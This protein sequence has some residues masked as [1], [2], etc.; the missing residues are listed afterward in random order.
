MDQEHC[1]NHQRMGPTDWAHFWR[2]ADTTGEAGMECLHASFQ[3]HVYAP[4]THDTFVIGI[5]E[6]GIERF[7]V[8]G[9]LERAGPGDVCIVPPDTPHDGAPET[10]DGYTYR[11]IYPAPDVVARVT[12]DVFGVAPV[13]PRFPGITFADRA[14]SARLG[15][16]HRTLQAIPCPLAR[17]SAVVGA[18]GDLIR[19]HASLTRMPIEQRGVPLALA[20][21]K[22]AIDDDPAA[23][24]E[25]PA[26]AGLADQSPYQFIRAF[27]RAYGMTPHAYV[28]DRRVALARRVLRAGITP[29][30]AAARTGFCD[31]SHL[32]RAFKARYGVTPGIFRAGPEARL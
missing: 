14:V 10:E 6:Q 3:T 25:L 12:A 15:G 13:L 11:M 21:A 24:H 22:M 31:Q 5:I 29:S 17:Q 16:M 30:E 27:R 8:A 7:T 26:L 1:I 4:H 20:Q 9:S 23:A 2:S 18:L 19:R 28:T 32:N